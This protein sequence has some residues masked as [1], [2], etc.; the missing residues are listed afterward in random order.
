MKHHEAELFSA[1]VSFL[2]PTYTYFSEPEALALKNFVE[3]GNKYF[4]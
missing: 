1:N 3:Q 2:Q 4:T